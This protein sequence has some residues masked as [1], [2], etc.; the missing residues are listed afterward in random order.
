MSIALARVL[1]LVERLA[2]ER[3]IVKKQTPVAAAGRI[4]VA[5]NKINRFSFR[6]RCKSDP[7][8]EKAKFDPFQRRNEAEKQR[9]ASSSARRPGAGIA[10]LVKNYQANTSRLIA[11]AHDH[12]INQHV[13]ALFDVV[14]TN[15]RIFSDFRGFDHSPI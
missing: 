11:I 8:F 2:A 10:N 6:T 15:L 13:V 9:L 1:S 12:F 4:A 5:P 3:S 14:N 7:R